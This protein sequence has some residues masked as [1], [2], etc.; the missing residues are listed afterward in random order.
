MTEGQESK[1]QE[2]TQSLR[3][4]KKSYFE[5]VESE[6]SE[7]ESEPEEGEGQP[8]QVAPKLIGVFYIPP[9]TQAAGSSK[10]V[11]PEKGAQ[12]SSISPNEK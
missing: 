10:V 3:Y 9:E 4:L 6:E 5:D 11:F 2:F 1:T 7:E 8:A 12:E